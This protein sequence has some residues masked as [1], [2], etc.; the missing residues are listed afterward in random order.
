VS[1]VRR[2]LCFLLVACLCST[3]QAQDE[4]WA[5]SQVKSL[6]AQAQ[7]EAAAG[8][9]DAATKLFHDA[10]GIDGSYA[11]LY[12]GLGALREKV[13]DAREAEQVYS[14]GIEQLPGFWEGRVARARLRWKLA[15]RAE[16]KADLAEA[17]T[18]RKSD[19]ALLEELAGWCV[20]DSDFPR[21]L[22][23]YRR[24]RRQLEVDGDEATRGRVKL[25]IKALGLL[26]GGADPLRAGHFKSDPVRRGIESVARAQG[27]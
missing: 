6:A 22:A 19:A 24:A 9:A 4:N 8:R 1:A 25:K 26:V 15:R 11:P 12:L 27:W 10:L 3:A 21:A 18:Q 23:L 17:L 13:G 14:V 16:A 5:R 7:A 2:V 20:E